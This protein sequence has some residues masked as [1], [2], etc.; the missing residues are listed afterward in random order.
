MSKDLDAHLAASLRQTRPFPNPETAAYLALMRVASRFDQE[1][2]DLLRP[3]GITPTQYNVL[4]ILRGAGA[5]G[6]T[7]T[8]VL[9]R[10]VARDPDITRLLDRLEKLGLVTR[11]RDD[12]D[13][14]IVLSRITEAGLALLAELDAPVAE[15]HRSQLGHLGESDLAELS[16]LLHAMLSEGA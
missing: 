7:C 16:R 4:R 15:L 5:D 12:R 3:R 10:L 14:R 13:R 1:M 6:V 2:S 9:E 8:G 11:A